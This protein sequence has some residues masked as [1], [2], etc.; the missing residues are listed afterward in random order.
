M[1][2]HVSIPLF[3]VLLILGIWITWISWNGFLNSQSAKDKQL[4]RLT[5]E[6]LKTID[7]TCDNFVSIKCVGPGEYLLETKG[8]NDAHEAGKFAYNA[9]AVLDERN[10]VV[11]TGRASFVIH[12]FQ[13][14]EPIFD[15]TWNFTGLPKVKLLGPFEDFDFTP[16]FG[17]V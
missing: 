1:P 6:N 2:K 8:L 5:G 17:K 13:N 15:V 14:G 3:T 9:M 16:S 4:A 12:G 10:T 7:L 11:L